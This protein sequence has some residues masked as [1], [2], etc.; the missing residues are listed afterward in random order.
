V[1]PLFFYVAI[2]ITG[3][4]RSAIL[5]IIAFFAVGALLLARVDPTEGARVARAAEADVRAVTA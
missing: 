2:E 3:S 1:G 5:S 4:S